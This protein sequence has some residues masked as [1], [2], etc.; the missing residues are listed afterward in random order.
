MHY[1]FFCCIQQNDTVGQIYCLGYSTIIVTP[2][3]SKGNLAN[4]HN[5]L[6]L[7]SFL[8]RKYC[9]LSVMVVVMPCMSC[10][11]FPYFIMQQ[12]DQQR[13]IENSFLV[14][15]QPPCWCKSPQCVCVGK[16]L[17]EGSTWHFR[18]VLYVNVQENIY[19]SACKMPKCFT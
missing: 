4:I 2:T 7:H 14:H 16:I 10:K 18:V 15:C 17:K 19:P 6:I 12:L 5:F 3:M 1:I 9:I 11:E 13:L 8:T